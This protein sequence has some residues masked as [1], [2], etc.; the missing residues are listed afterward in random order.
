[1]STLG[2][3]ARAS[4]RQQSA[5]FILNQGGPFPSG[6]RR[7]GAGNARSPGGR[8]CGRGSTPRRAWPRSRR[9][10]RKW[11][12][13]TAVTRLPDA[14][15]LAVGETDRPQFQR[16]GARPAQPTRR[17]RHADRFPRHRSRNLSV[18]G[19]QELPTPMRYAL[20][21]PTTTS[22]LNDHQ[23]SR[24]RHRHVNRG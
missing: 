23:R 1:V 4:R 17:H 6:R 15:G 2:G 16:R 21:N 18:A 5:T 24:R 20:D 22:G 11:P 3:P 19:G 12:T 8:S 14:A 13:A 7:P 9:A 10:E